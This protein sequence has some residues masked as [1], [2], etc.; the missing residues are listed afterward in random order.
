MAMSAQIS[1][2]N[3]FTLDLGQGSELGMAL[4]LAMMMFSVALGLRP[5]HFAAIKDRPRAYV[6]GVVAQLLALPL[7][8]VVLVHLLNPLPSIALGMILVA[9][10]PGGN[11]SNMLV[12]L[13]NGNTALSVSLTATSSLAAAF[14]TP[15]SILFWSSLYVPTANL[16]TE[17][18][19]DAVSFLIQT[20]IIL[21]LPLLLGMLLLKLNPQLAQTIRKPLVMLST[22]ALFGIIIVAS[23]RYWEMFVLLGAMII[24]IVALHNASAFLL[25][26]FSARLASASM[27]ERRT[28]T[29]EVGIQNSGLGIV[30]LLTQMGGLGGT[31]AIAGLWGVWHILAGLVLV[32]IFRKLV[33]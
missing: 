31:A 33:D 12:L 28:L 2:I 4:A 3:Q 23:V 19:F 1:D 25:G 5:A 27:S 32:V 13:V 18:E 14:I 10:C 6:A 16:L 7:L 30:I 20:S 11:V 29:F 8:T 15:V 22:A 24:G 26:Y 21:A 17:I 9:C